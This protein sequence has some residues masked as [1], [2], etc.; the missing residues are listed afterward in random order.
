[1]KKEYTT[2]TI[3]LTQCL[4]EGIIAAS[5]GHTTEQV[6]PDGGG[7]IPSTDDGDGQKAKENF[8]D[9]TTWED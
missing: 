5:P 1:M 6:T 9:W 4:L 8:N 7:D 2:P 3:V